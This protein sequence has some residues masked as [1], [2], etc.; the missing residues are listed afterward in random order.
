VAAHRAAWE[1]AGLAP[2]SPARALLTETDP[3]R[4]IAL[5][6]TS[7]L[8]PAE[9]GTVIA[10]AFASLARSARLVTAA[11]L[12]PRLTRRPDLPASAIETVAE[13]YAAVVRGGSERVAVRR[14]GQDWKRQILGT[15]LAELDPSTDRDRV[16]H[17]AAATLMAEE[18]R[19]EIDDLGR[20][21]D[22]ARDVL[23]G[24]G[25]AAA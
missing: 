23:A 10:D 20:A 24:A 9:A 17:N 7:P 6:L 16:I 12:F 19:F 21:F 5:A 11:V 1:A 2:G 4:L 13:A 22:H 3:V 14:G 18:T 8:D 25:E 15:R